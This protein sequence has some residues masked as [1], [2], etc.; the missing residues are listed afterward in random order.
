VLKRALNNGGFTLIELLIVSVIILVLLSFSTPLFRRSF[1]DLELKDTAS[2]ITKFMIF[3]QQRAI[4][5]RSVYKISFDF[6]KKTYRLFRAAGE[7]QNI[8]YTAA[9]DRFGNIIHLPKDI[10]CEGQANEIFF[11]PD[12]HCDAVELRLSNSNKKALIISITGV[13]GNAV[14]REEKE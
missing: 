10:D 12:G 8:T 11:Y 9:Q 5:D 4:I 3:A 7:G 1:S 2:S 13:L 6:Y 14:I